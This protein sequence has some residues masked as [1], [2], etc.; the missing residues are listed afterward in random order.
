SGWEKGHKKHEHDFL[1]TTGSCS[2]PAIPDDNDDDGD[3]D[4]SGNATIEKLRARI[5]DL[6]YRISQFEREVIQRER[7]LIKRVNKVLTNR[8]HGHILLQVEDNGEAWYVDEDSDQ[9]Y[10]LRDGRS[11]YQALQAFGLGI[12]D[13]DLEKIPVGLN[14]QF[15]FTD[16]DGDGLPDQLEDSLGTD[17]ADAD[18][19]NDGLSDRQELI[20]NYDPRGA[21]PFVYNTALVDRLRGKILLQ[22]QKH[23]EAWWI[24]P[25]DG[26]RYYMKD[27]DAAYNI[28]RF[29]SL[30]IANADLQQIGVGSLETE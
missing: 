8:L 4:S 11:A 28:M 22:V 26:K 18:T 1:A 6:Q 3:D 27:G 13:T 25:A 29:L 9:R 17:P 20:N 14:D 10:Y 5:R 16:S 15:V 2:T 7:Q 30:G 12:S 21:R 24:N 19:D 23:G